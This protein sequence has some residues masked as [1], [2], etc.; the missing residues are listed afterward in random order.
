MQFFF[1]EEFECALIFSI[2]KV[3]NSV[4]KKNRVN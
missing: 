1:V 2:L 4:A 3:V